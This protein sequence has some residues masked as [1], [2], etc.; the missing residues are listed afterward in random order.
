MTRVWQVSN[1]PVAYG[2]RNC[3]LDHGLLLIGP[4]S[5]G[6]WHP[7]RDDRDFEGAY[8]RRLVEEMQEGDAVVLRSGASRSD[9]PQAPGLGPVRSTA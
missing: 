6:P 2:E 5:A 4:G 7:G 8:T 9:Q 1:A 3:F